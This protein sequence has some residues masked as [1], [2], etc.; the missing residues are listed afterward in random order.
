MS[1]G[2]TGAAVAAHGSSVVV[3]GTHNGTIDYG[4]GP[5]TATLG[6]TRPNARGTRDSWAQER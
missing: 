2:Q 6:G 3:A 4:D 1:S 5:M